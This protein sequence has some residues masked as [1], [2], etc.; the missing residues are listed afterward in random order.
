M[1]S[2]NACVYC[3][4]PLEHTAFHH[5]S[6]RNRP[7]STSLSLARQL[8]V[9]K[10]PLRLRSKRG[11]GFRSVNGSR[12]RSWVGGGGAPV[13]LS[14]RT[15]PAVSAGEALG[16]QWQ[17]AGWTAP[18]RPGLWHKEPFPLC[19]ARPSGQPFPWC[20]LWA[21]AAG[22]LSEYEFWEG[23]HPLNQTAPEW[24][25]RGRGG[26]EGSA[27]WRAGS[28][29]GVWRPFKPLVA[30]W[31]VCSCLDTGTTLWWRLAGP[32]LLRAAWGRLGVGGGLGGLSYRRGGLGASR[33][34]KRVGQ[35]WGGEG[36]SVGWGWLPGGFGSLCFRNLTVSGGC[37]GRWR[38][39]CGL[40]K[41][42]V[43]WFRMRKQCG[44]AWLH[45]LVCVCVP[46]GCAWVGKVL[47][48]RGRGLKV[49]NLSP[50]PRIMG[51]DF[52][53]ANSHSWQFDLLCPI[54]YSVCFRLS[55]DLKLFSPLTLWKMRILWNN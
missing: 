52:W 28:G 46:W 16:G 10:R 25:R 9:G 35:F 55:F 43:T 53:R 13:R 15:A 41:N 26:G 24:A 33:G 37:V 8:I 38:L 51:T 14:M 42:R 17:E 6:S 1:I 3:V 32:Y 50:L 22:S 2:L 21:W 7:L 4:S 34:M 11:N 36:V 39:K 48:G 20:S 30:R 31:G 19:R 47:M 27:K 29:S 40:S 12:F 5:K 54:T 23:W 45:R 44:R 49:S 18:G